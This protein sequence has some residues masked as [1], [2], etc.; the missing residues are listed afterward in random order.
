MVSF[1]RHSTFR[2]VMLM[3]Y[4]EL[5]LKNGVPAYGRTILVKNFDFALD[6]VS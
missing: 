4:N 2:K 5:L 1:L 6:E 3:Y